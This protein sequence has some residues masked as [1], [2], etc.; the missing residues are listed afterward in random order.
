MSMLNPLGKR[1]LAP[2]RR[3][4]HR[5]SRGL[6]LLLMVVML[7]GAAAGAWLYL[8]LG[9]DDDVAAPRASCP[10]TA[11]PPTVVAPAQVRVNVYNATQR[12]GLASA[13][14][15]EL[16]KRGFTVGKVT[17]DPLKRSVTGLAE[18]RASTAGADASRTVVAQVGQ[19]VLVPD[20][21]T[22]AS[23]DL[24]LGATFKALV[25]PAAAAAAVTPTPSPR[26]PGC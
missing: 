22:D 21:R 18:V 6:L 4:G 7:A 12:R 5:T 15:A 24:V 9:A 23:V 2:S 26:P 17:N 10:P 13:V 8:E 11:A 14:A 19:V 1:D 25:P 3:G 16:K 20:Q